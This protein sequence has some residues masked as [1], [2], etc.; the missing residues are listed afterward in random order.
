[1]GDPA[2]NL[3]SST[4]PMRVVDSRHVARTK[5]ALGGQRG[6]QSRK[7]IKLGR[8]QVNKTWEIRAEAKKMIEGGRLPRPLE[9]ID[10]LAARGITVSSGQVSLALQGT[11][12]SLR[13]QKARL[14]GVHG[15]VPD[16][17]AAIGAVSLDDVIRAREYIKAMGSVERAIAA[18]IA[19]REF[20]GGKNAD[21]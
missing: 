3:G 2:K 20:G 16:P 11:G 5:D 7:G 17:R 9:I 1:M 19:F 10:S 14:Y 13:D 4:A 21:T 18:I 12:M 6:R 8:R 15:I